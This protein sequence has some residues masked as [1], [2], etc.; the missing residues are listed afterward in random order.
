MSD[1]KSENNTW[2]SVGPYNFQP[3]YPSNT[4]SATPTT[5]TS[6]TND[7]YKE[8][9]PSSYLPN[10]NVPPQQQS[11]TNNGSNNENFTLLSDGYGN[12]L[13][14]FHGNDENSSINFNNPNNKYQLFSSS[15]TFMQQNFKVEDNYNAQQQQTP[16]A[17]T[18]NP[19]QQVDF[20][21]PYQSASAQAPL[22]HLH[23]LQQHQQQQHHRQIPLQNQQQQSHQTSNLFNHLNLESNSHQTS[24]NI[25]SNLSTEAKTNNSTNMLI[26]QLVGNWTPNISGTY[27]PFGESSS[28][29]MMMNSEPMTYN[30]HN[31]QSSSFIPPVSGLSSS[32]SPANVSQI[33]RMS[34]SMSNSP[35]P[36]EYKLP[37]S[38]AKPA[39]IQ[40]FQQTDVSSSGKL[41][42]NNNTNTANKK[43]RIVAEVKP[44]RMSYSAVLIKNVSPESPEQNGTSANGTAGVGSA[45]INNNY[46]S[47][48][49]VNSKSGKLTNDKI[50]SN[51]TS[52]T[53]H[54]DK[55][56]STSVPYSNA[57][58]DKDVLKNKRNQTQTIIGNAD[59][60]SHISTD[61]NKKTG[62]AN[63]VNNTGKVET[64]DDGNA[65]KNID[66][67]KIL[68]KKKNKIPSTLNN[69]GGSSTEKKYL[70]MSFDENTDEIEDD[71]DIDDNSEDM[72]DDE[73]DDETTANDSSDYLYNVRRNITYDN[74]NIEKIPTS[75]KTPSSQ[76][77]KSK[78]SSLNRTNSKQDKTVTTSSNS[79]SKRS[80]NNKKKNPKYQMIITLW[81]IWLEY[82]VKI[83]TWFWS[84]ISDVVYLSFGII[85]DKLN[86]GY[87][88]CQLTYVSI[89]NEIRTNSGRPNAWLKDCYKKFDSKFVP[90]SKWALWRKIFNRRKANEPIKD[91]YKD[92]RLPTTADEAMH[93]LL[94]CKGKNAYR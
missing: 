56:K 54:S 33:P 67:K 32:S 12:Y 53:A 78:I 44:M 82:M 75:I 65:T 21:F 39:P 16:S 3:S 89:K 37:S 7:Y 61:A 10:L 79:H 86:I 36:N 14:V 58:D 23:H 68:L 90:D 31:I 51:Y 19:S 38:I 63:F 50:K 40:K 46:N 76:F 69:S 8:S 25:N 11:Q 48:T 27:S 85:W 1:K 93:S 84:L 70:N 30:Q 71:D 2:N 83:L 20:G 64:K 81:N 47:T 55:S 5:E 87:Q 18:M 17:P 49:P 43:Q 62:N 45:G 60:S 42:Q 77:K 34:S 73:E 15:N 74:H 9:I 72:E 24:N 26:N 52:T 28:Q 59:K 41:N 22:S 91:Y 6:S 66:K 88:Y 29:Q 35:P 94:N 4:I 92:G 57:T 13:R 80:Y